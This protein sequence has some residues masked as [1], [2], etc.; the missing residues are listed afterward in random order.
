MPLYFVVQICSFRLNKMQSCSTQ[1]TK[2]FR[3][4]VLSANELILMGESVDFVGNCVMVINI[5]QKTATA[6]CHF[7]ER[8]EEKS[9]LFAGFRDASLL[10]T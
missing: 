3:Q 5:V 9:L 1:P 10:S 4:R 8:S 7:D 6:Y 2:D